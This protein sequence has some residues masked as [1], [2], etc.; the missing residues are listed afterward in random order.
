VGEECEGEEEGLIDRL[1]MAASSGS[2][3]SM[4]DGNSLGTALNLTT[5]S[6]YSHSFSTANRTASV[7]SILMTTLPILF[8]PLTILWRS[9]N[10]IEWLEKGSWKWKAIAYG[11]IVSIALPNLLARSYD[12]NPFIIFTSINP[13]YNRQKANSVA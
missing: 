12:S 2:L 3:Y 4:Q 9:Q 10:S 8:I 13:F 7:G 6:S 1:C 5:K 11:M